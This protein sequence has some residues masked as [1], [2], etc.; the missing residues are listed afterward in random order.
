[1]ESQRWGRLAFLQT[2]ITWRQKVRTSL[3]V[4][5]FCKSKNKTEKLLH[6]ERRRVAL[7]LDQQARDGKSFEFYTL[8]ALTSLLRKV[9][10]IFQPPW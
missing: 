5:S 9:I 7:H 3:K 6:F 2:T 10:A 4:C 1:M 8:K